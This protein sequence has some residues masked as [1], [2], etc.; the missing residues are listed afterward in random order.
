MQRY[1]DLGGNS[2]VLGFEI[3][4]NSTPFAPVSSPRA[5]FDRRSPVS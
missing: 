3:G 5:G 1:S 2:G 4:A